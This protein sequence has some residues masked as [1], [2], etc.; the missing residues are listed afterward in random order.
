MR[1]IRAHLIGRCLRLLDTAPTFMLEKGGD[2]SIAYEKFL[3]DLDELLNLCQEYKLAVSSLK[4]SQFREVVVQSEILVTNPQFERKTW[5][6]L[7]NML[8]QIPG[9]VED[10]LSLRHVYVLD[11]TDVPLFESPY[12]F[13]EDVTNAFPSTAFDI[14]EAGKCLSLRRSTA[15]V[16]HLTRV[17]QAGLYALAVDVGVAPSNRNWEQ[18][19]ADVESAIRSQKAMGPG[20]NAPAP[21]KQAWKAIVEFNAE[22]AMQFTHIKDA[23]RNQ[24]IHRTGLIYTEEKARSIF[25]ASR[26]FMAHLATKLREPSP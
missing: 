21:D 24:A 10:E 23:F 25:D 15:C 22:A 2:S 7:L 18:V 9:V 19:I 8:R 1:P 17:L 6:R 11:D 13:G 5:Q 3:S 26:A 4:I 12:P 14:E 20:P 16:F